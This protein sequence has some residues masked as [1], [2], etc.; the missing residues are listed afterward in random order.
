M[1]FGHEDIVVDPHQL[2]CKKSCALDIIG[3]QLSQGSVFEHRDCELRPILTIIHRANHKEFFGPP[4][5]F[6]NLNCYQVILFN[7]IIQVYK[8]ATTNDNQWKYIYDNIG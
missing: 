6:D 7:F 8:T 3:S 2:R 4:V 1:Y 5:I